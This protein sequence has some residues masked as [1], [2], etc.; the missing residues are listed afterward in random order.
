MIATLLQLW[1]ASL[2]GSAAQ[3][4]VQ[5][6]EV[7]C[8]ECSICAADEQVEIARVALRRARQAPWAKQGLSGLLRAPAQWAT[9]SGHCLVR[10]ELRTEPRRWRNYLAAVVLARRELATHGP[11]FFH[12]RRLGRIWTFPEQPVPRS[13]HHRFFLAEARP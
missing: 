10:S 6:A 9:P 13:W 8:A 2:I 3:S 4:Y 5:L 7:V 1:L 12:T 11:V